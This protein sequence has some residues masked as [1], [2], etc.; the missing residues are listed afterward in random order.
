MNDKERRTLL[1]LQREIENL[2]DE[3]HARLEEI[4][5]RGTRVG[6]SKTPYTPTEG[7]VGGYFLRKLLIQVDGE[8]E[9]C[10]AD[11]LNKYDKVRK[12]DEDEA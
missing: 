9:P 2:D 5:P 8:R 1:R 3:Y 6:F 11:P 4:F 10:Y 7:K 12:V